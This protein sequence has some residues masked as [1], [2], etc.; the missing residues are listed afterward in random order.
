MGSRRWFERGFRFDLPVEHAPNL[1]ERLRGTPLRVAERLKGVP[2]TVLV[3]REDDAWSLQE[4]VGHLLVLESLWAG[5][6]EDALA[7]AERLRPADLSNA[8][9]FEG[10]FNDR[11]LSDLLVGFA[12]ARKVLVSRLEG[13]SDSEWLAA[14]LHPRLE[15][16]MRI[17][18]L[19][20]FVAEHDDH[21]LVRISEL[22]RRFGG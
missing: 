20:E 18:D 19:A 7:G 15:Q 11:E 8:A 5:R 14:G 16:P 22:L 2:A 6:V 1:V 12:A 9:T 4:Q 21:H 10:N 13:L 17:L 3:L